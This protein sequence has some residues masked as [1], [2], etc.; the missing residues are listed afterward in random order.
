MI[1]LETFSNKSVLVKLDWTNSFLLNGP[2][3]SYRLFINNNS[4]YEGKNSHLI[5]LIE[6]EECTYKK[7]TN[8]YGATVRGYFNILDIGLQV[9]TIYTNETIQQVKKPLNCTRN[10]YDKNFKL[11]FS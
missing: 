8:S 1:S 9:R 6:P 5:T 10:F 2:L 7:F 11:C 4:I 3:V